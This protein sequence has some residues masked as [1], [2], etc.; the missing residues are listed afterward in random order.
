M[1]F[2]VLAKEETELVV[3]HIQIVV[4]AI[5]TITA[6]YVQT[7]ALARRA[8]LHLAVHQTS[9]LRSSVLMQMNVQTSQ[10]GWLVRRRQI[11]VLDFVLVLL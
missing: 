5:A 3:Y 1:E 9:V 7:E 11:A 10:M 6:M 8:P 2:A 4:L